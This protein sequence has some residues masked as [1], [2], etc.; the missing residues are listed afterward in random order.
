MD[1]TI[2]FLIPEEDRTAQRRGGTSYQGFTFTVMHF[3]IMVESLGVNIPLLKSLIDLSN[4]SQVTVELYDPARKSV[5]Y[6]S[7]F[8]KTDLQR[9]RK[10]EGYLYKAVKNRHIPLETFNGFLSLRFP[11]NTVPKLPEKCAVTYSKD[12]GPV[13]L[14]H[15]TGLLES[16]SSSP[17]PFSKYACPLVSLQYSMLDPETLKRLHRS[18]NQ[19]I[20]METMKNKDFKRKAILEDEEYGDMLFLPVID[21]NETDCEKFMHLSQHFV[22]SVDFDNLLLVTDE[23]LVILDNIVNKLNS[24]ISTNLWWS[25][26]ESI[27]RPKASMLPPLLVPKHPTMLLS[28]R[29]VEYISQSRTY[30]ENFAS[31]LSS[32]GIW[33]AGIHINIVNDQQWSQKIPQNM[34]SLDVGNSKLAFPG[35]SAK[36][37]KQIWGALNPSVQCVEKSCN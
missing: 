22:E 18:K 16:R 35:I 34:T 21:S 33:F 32:L 19:Q 27:A 31:L 37:M 13:G 9:T 10:S 36:V 5:V 30:L 6:Q 7:S 29:L 14:V 12:F 17:L 8:N 3:P 25:D 2:P 24:H 26:F 1:D 15:V 11:P 4:S 28:M 20:E 23:S